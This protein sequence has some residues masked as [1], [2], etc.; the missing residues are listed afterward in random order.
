MSHYLLTVNSETGGKYTFW[1]TFW[2]LAAVI[3][4]VRRARPT[5]SDRKQ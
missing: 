1:L 2:E 5:V 3:L 4:G